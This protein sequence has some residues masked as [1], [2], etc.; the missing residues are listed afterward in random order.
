MHRHHGRLDDVALGKHVAQWPRCG[1]LRR[2][3]ET[4]STTLTEGGKADAVDFFIGGDINIE[5]KLGNAGED[6]QDL[7]KGSQL[8][9]GTCTWEPREESTASTCRPC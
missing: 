2:A 9:R 8:N 1:G 3:F 6:L 7:D 4:V 5:L